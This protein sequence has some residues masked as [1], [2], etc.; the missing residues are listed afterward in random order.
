MSSPLLPVFALE[1]YDEAGVVLK[2]PEGLRARIFVAEDDIVRFTL[3]PA[4]GLRQARTWAIAPGAEDVP[5]EGRDRFDGT[6]F[7]QPGFVFEQ[8]EGALLVTTAQLRLTLELAGLKCRWESRIRGEWRKVA[9][10]RPT[11][12]CNFGQWG[13]GVYHYLKRDAGDMVFGLGERAGCANRSGKR[14]RMCNIDAMGYD[15]RTSDPLYKHIPFYFVWRRKEQSGVGLFY[16]TLADCVFDMGCEID[17][18]HGPYRYF[19]A[20][21]G[22]LDYW[23]I[24]G[25]TPAAITRRFTWLT[26][27]PAFMPKWSLGYS[28]STMTYTDAP[29]AA[30][31][32][33]EFLVKCEEHDILCESFHLSSGYTTIGDHRYVFNWNRDKFPDPKAFADG[34]LA[35]GVRLIANIKPAMLHDHPRFPEAAREGLFVR[36]A[37]GTPHMLQFWGSAA[38]YLDFTNPRTLAWWKARVTDALLDF[39][40]AA[41]WNDNNEFEIWNPDALAEGFGRPVQAKS[42]RVLATLLMMRASREA[43]KEHAP[44]A[45]PFL[46]SR[47][48]AAGMQRYAQTWSGDNSTSWE[49]LKYNVRMGTGLAMSGVSN[50]GHDVGGFAGPAPDAELLLR[51]VQFGIFLPRFSIHSWNDDGTVNE[52][53]MY[54]EITPAIADLIKFRASLAPYL[55][56]LAWKSHSRYEPMIR[57]IYYDFPHDERTFEENDEM[58]LG[59]NLLVAPVVEP[60]ARERTVYLPAG[61]DWCDYWSGEYFAGGR[62]VRL[63]APWDRPPLLARAG[64]V[65]AL[66]LA[67]QHFHRS[68]DARGF[69]LFPPRGAGTSV[70]TCFED[71]G[72]SEAYRGGRFGEWTLRLEASEREILVDLGWTGAAPRP[73]EALTLRLPRQDARRLSIVGGQ[74]RESAVCGSRRVIRVKV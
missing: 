15:A 12:A 70:T 43:Q 32:M 25:E 74:A 21:A 46:V 56:D 38:A 26:G 61:A 63:P 72:E 53:W 69:D 49:T 37:D 35:R 24:A 28:A 52:P 4:R 71:D 22:D 42:Q 23:V 10:D 60:G 65:I 2:G 27:K 64:S 54:R 68:A 45:R 58:M 67:E 11:Q 48:G 39:G 33:G 13:D 7:S 9:E 1:A 5:T 55:Y 36:E 44:Q 19:A 18:Y 8:R 41:T 73:A 51:W 29:N 3:V 40:I 34:Y 62:E 20:E 59:A 16:D 17:N 47:A 31:R 6:G 50:L 30:E 66:N 14:Y 57:P